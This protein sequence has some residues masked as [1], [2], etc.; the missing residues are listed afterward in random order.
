MFL[1]AASLI[2]HLTTR[3]KRQNRIIEE[4]EDRAMRLFNL[5]HSIS[6]ANSVEGVVQASILAMQRTFSAEVAVLLYPPEGKP[7]LQKGSTFHPSEKEFAV[8]EWV[9]KHAKPA[10]RLTD[11]LPSAD[12][13][14]LPLQSR[15]VVIGALGLRLPPQTVMDYERLDLAQALAGQLAAGLERETLHESRKRLDVLEQADRLFRTLFDSVSHELKTPLTTIKGATSALIAQSGDTSPEFVGDLVNQIGGETERLLNV[16]N[17]M[18]DMTRLESGSLRP[19]IGTYDIADL[20]GPSLKCVEP[21]RKSRK[22][23][24]EILANVQPLSCDAPLA[25]QAIANI[26]HNSVIHTSECG[27]IEIHALNGSNGTV[28]IRIKDD[29]PGLPTENPNIVFDKFYRERPEKSG[30]VGLGL[31]I[32]RG[33][34]EV[35]GG[36]LTAANDPSRGAVFTIRLPAG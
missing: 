2:G 23:Q 24:T 35:Q 21:M 19:K 3:L 27:S 36:S 4:R 20:L 13:T 1:L 26:L 9:R 11:T 33:F 15:K 16:V 17:N 31:S 25:V 34:I 10:G 5:A 12:G 30:G 8:A 7:Q 6:E 18:L 32:A 29:G 28:E 22:I 14:Y